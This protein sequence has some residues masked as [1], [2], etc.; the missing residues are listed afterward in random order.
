MTPDELVKTA[1]PAIA[2]LGGQFYF[3]P[4]TIARGKEHGLDGMRF[5]I[6][7]RGGVLGDVEPAVVQSAFGYFSAGVIT[8]LWNSAREKMAPRDAGRLY[9]EC[10]ATFGRS[11]FADLDLEGFCAAAE[12]VVAAAHPAALALYAG[13]AAEPRVDDSAGRAMQL[14]VVLREFRGSAHLVAV[15]ASGVQAEV[16]HFIRRPD[17]Y[18]GFG[19]DD[20]NPP[21]V[22]DGDHANL[23]AAEA[24][25]DKLVLPAYAALD[26]NEAKVFSAGA[27]AMLAAAT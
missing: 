7:G 4:A 15:L 19:Y 2:T 24:L 26:A 11:R 17:M 18:K 23:V 10:A 6:L 9:H 8:K 27:E 14:A 13:W 1:C 3:D 25:T 20:A 12:K 5:Y 22:T 16:A 21:K